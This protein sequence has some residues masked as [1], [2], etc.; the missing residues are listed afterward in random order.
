MT[1]F[2]S[3]TF[4]KHSVI[5][6]VGLLAYITLLV[7]VVITYEHPGPFDNVPGITSQPPAID[8]LY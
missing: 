2:L 4:A 7:L 8:R 1:K 5:K 3:Q 6:I